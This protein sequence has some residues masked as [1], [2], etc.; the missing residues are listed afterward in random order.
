[1]PQGYQNAKNKQPQILNQALSNQFPFFAS[2][3]SIS[4]PSCSQRNYPNDFWFGAAPFKLVFAQIILKIFNM[5]Q[6]NLLTF[7]RRKSAL[8]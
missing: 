5:S 6:F 4:F 7:C 8:K 2:A 3:L 1:M